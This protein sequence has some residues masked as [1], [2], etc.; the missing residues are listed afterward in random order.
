MTVIN[1]IL[2][3]PWTNNG[4]HGPATMTGKKFFRILLIVSHEFRRDQIPLR[5]GALA[6]TVLL[7]LVPVLALGTSVMKGFGG[8]GHLRTTAH[9][10]INRIQAEIGPPRLTKGGE[11]T[12][13][14]L[15]E[16]MHRAVDQ[17]FTYVDRT[18]FA[19]LG[20]FGI[21]GVIWAAL[22]VLGNIER[23]MNVIWHTARQRNIFR[24]IIDYLALTMLMPLSINIGLA[25]MTAMNSSKIRAYLL[26]IVPDPVI[27]SRI[28]SLLP[29][30]LL[31][32]TF[33]T[34]Y[35]FLPN[36]R[37]TKTAAFTGGVIGS[38]SWLAFQAVYLKLQF[39]V[40]RYNAIYGSFAT[41]P[42]FF[43][44]LYVGW[45]IFL[46][47]AEVS[48]AVQN[49]GTYHWHSRPSTPLSRLKLAVDIMNHATCAFA[50]R[51][52]LRPYEII[53]ATGAQDGEVREIVDLL[54]AHGLLVREKKRFYPTAPKNRIPLTEISDLILGKSEG[55]EGPAGIIAEAVKKAG[56]GKDI[57]GGPMKKEPARE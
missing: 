1:K 12:P 10:L 43:L 25:A 6:F 38:I 36:T 19:T 2:A 41:L 47:G 24:K 32:I 30:A 18:N 57:T 50:E 22:S 21:I 54:H 46:A 14:T 33:T 8:A 3:W 20:T 5:S 44:W 17:I 34:M 15:T 40:A 39:G 31:I 37:V 56:K 26:I 53:H 48:F 23:A 9:Q 55:E 27:L 7:S 49:H 52:G 51:K 35:A 29:V 13:A 11:D 42:L 45:M 4:S 28:L 16:Q